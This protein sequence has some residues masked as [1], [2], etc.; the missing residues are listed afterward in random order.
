MDS[1]YTERVD[2]LSQFCNPVWTQS[3]RRGLARTVFGCLSD[4]LRYR[5]NQVSADYLW[6][7]ICFYDCVQR[8]ATQLLLQWHRARSLY[9]HAHMQTHTH[10]HANTHTHT[11]M[12]IHTHTYRS[13]QDPYPDTLHAHS[14]YTRTHTVYTYTHANTHTHTH[15]HTHTYTETHIW[16]VQAQ[17]RGFLCL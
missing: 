17:E 13:V 3:T 1:K 9:P 15:T 5:S 10:T 7:E 12:Q 2:Y 6:A 11:H 8:L 14:T 4:R 16:S